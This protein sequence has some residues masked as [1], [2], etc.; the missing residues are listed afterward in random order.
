MY[1]GLQWLFKKSKQ[2]SGGAPLRKQETLD[3][4]RKE[5]VEILTDSKTLKAGAKGKGAEA[6]YFLIKD[7]PKKKLTEEEIEKL[8]KLLIQKG[9]YAEGGVVLSN[10]QTEFIQLALD[11]HQ[12]QED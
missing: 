10:E 8:R 2:V 12:E 6:E 3:F 4:L 9:S 1:D 7:F 11:V 5:G